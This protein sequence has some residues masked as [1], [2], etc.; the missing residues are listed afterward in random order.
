MKELIAFLLNEHDKQNE[1][2]ERLER[3]LKNQ[4][5][6]GSGKG[7]IDSEGYRVQIKKACLLREAL[8]EM[9][10]ITEKLVA[11]TNNIKGA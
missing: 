10:E 2:I 9:L 4:D 3:L 8:E 6:F 1:N 7:S 11:K 5:D